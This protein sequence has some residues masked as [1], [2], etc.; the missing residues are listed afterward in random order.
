[1]NRLTIIEFFTFYHRKV[2]TF[3]QY[4]ILVQHDK[5]HHTTQDSSKKSF[6][7]SNI[8]HCQPLPTLRVV[9]T[10]LLRFAIHKK[11]GLF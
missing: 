8:I 11:K 10:A 9:C 5:I 4:Y 3:I 7:K 2:Y 6:E 1:M